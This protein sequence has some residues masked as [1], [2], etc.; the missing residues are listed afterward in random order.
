MTI[1]FTLPIIS[2]LYGISTFIIALVIGAKNKKSVLD[3]NSD[4]W[5]FSNGFQKLYYAL[6]PNTDAVKLSKAFGLEYDKYMV[7]CNIIDR[8]PNME[9][10]A[11]MR[12]IGVFSF[13][14]SLLLSLLFFSIIPFIIGAS[15]YILLAS[16]IPRNT[17]A[18]AEAKKKCICNELSRFVDLFLSALEINFPVDIAII[19]TAD[20]LPCI[21]SHELKA[22]MAETQVGAKNWQ[23]ALE[24]IARKYEIDQLSDFVLDIITA[25]N[26]GISVTDAVAR[27]AFEIKQTVLLNAKEKTAKM[28][29]SILVPLIIFKI[30]PLLAILMIPIIQEVFVFF[31]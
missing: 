10:E 25:S 11:M 6:F 3:K 23:Q 14:L 27:K 9:K 17:H 19:Q 12:V 31:G 16:S 2:I 29:N 15:L 7:D 28:T 24:G 13:I 22:A 30:L 8:V 20:S 21:L 26:K 4:D 5:L 1:S 18:K